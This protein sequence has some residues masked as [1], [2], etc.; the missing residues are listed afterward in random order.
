MSLAINMPKIARVLLA[1]GWHEC[2]GISIDAYE[3]GAH[4]WK[5]WPSGPDHEF[6]AKQGY[7][8]GQDGVCAAG[9]SFT[10]TATGQTICGPM[11]TILAV[12]GKGITADPGDDDRD[13]C[14]G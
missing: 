6:S 3:F 14:G 1:D 2:R 10:D 7:V 13:I 11:T 5:H 12:A 9:F 4:Y 8:G